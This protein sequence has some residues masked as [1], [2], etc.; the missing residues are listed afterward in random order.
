MSESLFLVASVLASLGV[1]HGFGVRGSDARAPEGLSLAR[2][3]HGTMLLRAPLSVTPDGVTPEAATPEAD[4][5]FASDPGVAVGVR[6]ADCV[7]LLF[8][9]RS[10]RGVAAVHAGWRGIAAGVAPRT[11]SGLAR[12][13]GVP[14]VDWVVAIGPHIGPCCY[15]VDEPV[16]R[17]IEIP[18]VFRPGRDAGHW[19]LDLERALVEQLERAGVSRIDSVG[20][21]TC[22]HP[23]TYPSHRRDPGGGRM[24]H[25]VR[26]PGEAFLASL[27]H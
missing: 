9:D 19:Q 27:S 7:P 21:C 15:E 6:T 4:A 22:C 3:V 8:A 12:E 2:Q 18:A 24:L 17:A 20:E 23:L 5:L 26:M 16:R 13:L 10:G 11:V 1:E 14:P 25:Y